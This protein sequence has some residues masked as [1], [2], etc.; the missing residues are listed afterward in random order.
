[1]IDDHYNYCVLI[2]CSRS[3][4]SRFTATHSFQMKR[5]ELRWG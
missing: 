2:G 3:E 4:L 1:M 5:D